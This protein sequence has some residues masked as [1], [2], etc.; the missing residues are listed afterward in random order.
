M[1][2]NQVLFFDTVRVL[3]EFVFVAWQQA[4]DLLDFESQYRIIFKTKSKTL[5][6][7]CHCII[8]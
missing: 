8:Y 2:S 4:R 5:H 1:Y 3:A 6:H 7:A